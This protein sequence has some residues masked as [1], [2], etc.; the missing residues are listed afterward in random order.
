MKS[1]QSI[2]SI[3][4]MLNNNKQ[5]QLIVMLIIFIIIIYFLL[6]NFNFQQIN[7]ETF[8]NSNNNSSISSSSNNKKE[9]LNCYLFYAYN[10]AHSQK[11]LKSHW[12]TLNEK[13][14][15]KIIF[16]KIDSLHPN[17]KEIS[18][19]FKIKEVPAIIIFKDTDILNNNNNN[20]VEFK[21]ERT[22][23]NLENFII[24]QLNINELNKSNENFV[25]TKLNTVKE[26]IINDVE[27]YHNEDLNKEEYQYSIKYK[28]PEK[29]IYN[30][31]QTINEKNSQL[32]SWQGSYTVMS[33]YIRYNTKT[34]K[35][36]KDLAFK[37]KDKIAEWH[38]CDPDILNIIKKNISAMENNQED[39]DINEAI[40]FACGF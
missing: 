17:T 31:S 2:Q 35:D 16:N 20:I 15:D 30:L 8:E 36:K 23:A 4:M 29:S 21:G 34:L 28:D 9:V 13:Y 18:K 27:F 5:I 1:I 11:L 19:K 3:L 40:R 37:I 33:E 6:F 32:K 10:C 26:D 14:S 39:L 22:L 24:K 25:D 38:L 7:L 12:K